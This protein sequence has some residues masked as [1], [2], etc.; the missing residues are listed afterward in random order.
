MTSRITAVDLTSALRRLGA[1]QKDIP[2]SKWH[3]FGH[4]K[5]PEKRYYVHPDGRLQV[6]ETLRKSIRITDIGK[7]SLLEAAGIYIN[8][9]G[10][11]L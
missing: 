2:L 1:P 7:E 11:T 10:A 8:E 3:C 9:Q 6:G 4:L 5:D